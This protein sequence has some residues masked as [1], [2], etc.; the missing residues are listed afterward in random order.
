MGPYSVFPL[1]HQ[2]LE[3]QTRKT[4]LLLC[5]TLSYSLPQEVKQK[6][7]GWRVGEK[8]P[9]PPAHP[10]PWK[11]L[12]HWKEKPITEYFSDSILSELTPNVVDSEGRTWSLLFPDLRKWT[13]L[14]LWDSTGYKCWNGACRLPVNVPVLGDKEPSLGRIT[15][16]PGFSGTGGFPRTWHFHC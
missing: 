15:N 2:L 8:H 11:L 16:C 12:D 4:T 6:S 10:G 9:P 14:G 1:G 5:S 7:Q 13:I 3:T